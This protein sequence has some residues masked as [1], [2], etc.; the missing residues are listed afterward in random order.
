MKEVDKNYYL[1]GPTSHQKKLKIL[2][3]NT[4]R[5][6]TY[7]PPIKRGDI[8]NAIN[9]GFNI[10]GIVDGFSLGKVQFRQEK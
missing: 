5:K 8:P 2:S 6:V 7:A 1:F 4:N 10:I 3:S 9:E